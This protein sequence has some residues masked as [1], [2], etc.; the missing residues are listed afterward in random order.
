M[1][2]YVFTDTN[3]FEQFQPITNIDWLTLAGCDSATLLV[4]GVTL[5]ELNEHKDGATRGRLKR[6]AAAALSDLKRYADRGTPAKIRD[7][8][9][10][11]FR[12]AE[13]LIDFSDY[14]LDKTL[15][16]DRLIASAIEFA[17]ENKISA[18][19]VLVATGDFGL[20]LKAKS[21]AMLR[22][23]S[24][25]DALRLPDEADEEEKQIRELKEEVRILRDALPDLD[26]AFPAASRVTT[27]EIEEPKPHE[28]GSPKDVVAEL[29]Q[30]YPYLPPE[31][32]HPP[33][34]RWVFCDIG[35]HLC[36]QYNDSLNQFFQRTE[37]WIR[38][39]ERVQNWYRTTIVLGLFLQNNGGAPGTDIDVE[40]Q[41][42]PEAHV[43]SFNRAPQI[44]AQPIPPIRPNDPTR[45]SPP[46]SQSSVPERFSLEPVSRDGKS[47]ISR[48]AS[49]FGGSLV[50]IHVSSVK[51]TYGQ[52]LPQLLVH[53]DSY[54]GA[55]SFGFGYRIVAANH[56]RP[57]EGHLDVIV[58]KK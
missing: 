38:E 3:L 31:P 30:E 43:V 28:L 10:L 51:H 2:K 12:T 32:G 16:D 45:T 19:C 13:P 5:R 6:K 55:G 39:S 36:Q 49:A 20:E 14:H 4:P 34:G 54:E 50:A 33:N 56:P 1:H 37:H 47:R 29:E 58:E 9:H 42:P 22:P 23:L 35:R 21:Q 17:S 53:L 26:L 15:G 11:D 18:E 27:V 24:M 57:V 41:F 25:P 8:V 44:P 40:V 7:G 46:I 48:I 52:E